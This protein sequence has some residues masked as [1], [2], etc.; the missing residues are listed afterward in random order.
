MKSLSLLHHQIWSLIWEQT[1]KTPPYAA[2][3]APM[4]SAWQSLGLWQLLC[5]GAYAEIN[6]LFL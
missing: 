6:T 3:L 2:L 1:K 5:F 4:P